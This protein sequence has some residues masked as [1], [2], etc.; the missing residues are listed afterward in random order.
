MLGLPQTLEQRNKSRE[1]IY[2]YIIQRAQERR[3]HGLLVACCEI[4]ADDAEAFAQST[5]GQESGGD[6]SIAGQNVPAVAGESSATL[7]ITEKLRRALKWTTSVQD[8]SI[9]ES[10]ALQLPL[11]IQEEQIAINLRQAPGRD[12]SGGPHCEQDIGIS[13]VALVTDSSC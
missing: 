12:H 2:E 7:E 5:T 6:S 13:S 10:L 3:L 11:A 8:E 4:S 9:I 1:E